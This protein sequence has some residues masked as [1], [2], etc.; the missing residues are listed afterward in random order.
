M[1]MGKSKKIT[2]LLIDVFNSKMELLAVDGEFSTYYDLLD[3]RLVEMPYRRVGG[4]YFQFICDE[5]GRY[6]HGDNPIPSAVND[7]LEVMLYGSLFVTN[8]GKNDEPTSLTE[9]DVSILLSNIKL[10][11]NP[12]NGKTAPLIVGMEY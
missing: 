3:C 5:E 7:D 12:T 6:S 8:I 10:Y 4:K 11:D 1:R 2:G 9:E